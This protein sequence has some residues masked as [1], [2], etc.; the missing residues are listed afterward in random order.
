[1]YIY[2][3]CLYL[4]I[5]NTYIFLF[6]D[7]ISNPDRYVLKPNREGGGNNIW[8]QNIANKLKEF[9]ES[10]RAEHILMQKLK[11]MVTKVKNKFCPLKYIDISKLLDKI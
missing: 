6:Q 9:T 8:G 2:D 4:I 5:L 11:P 1:M 3:A 10:D 7:A